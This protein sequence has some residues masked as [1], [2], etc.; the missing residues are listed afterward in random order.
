MDNIYVYYLDE[1]PG[2]LNEMVSPCIDGY[3]VYIRSGLD[4]A[5]RLKAYEHALKHIENGDFDVDCIKDVQQI[6]AEAHGPEKVVPVI[7]LQRELLELQIRRK[8]LN[9]EIRKKQR[10]VKRLIAQGHDFYAAEEDRW[11]EPGR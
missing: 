2:K 6:E 7:K 1:L 8:K 11:L 4:D 5:H 3:T 9:S 10:Q